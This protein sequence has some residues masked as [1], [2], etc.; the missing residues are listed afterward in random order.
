MASVKGLEKKGVQGDSGVRVV[1]GF[2]HSG[3]GVLSRGGI[4]RRNDP[5]ALAGTLISFYS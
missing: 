1:A 2:P 5:H 4:T 3:E